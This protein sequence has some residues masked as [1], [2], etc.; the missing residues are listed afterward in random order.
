[1]TPEGVGASSVGEVAVP[2]PARGV[3]GRLWLAD[4]TAFDG[5]LA[6]ALPSGGAVTGEVVFNTVMSGY[7]EVLTDPSYAGQM[8]AFTYPHIG[9]YGV[10][11][12]DAEGSRVHA[13]AAV[14]RELTARPA[15]W[16]AERSLE[17][18]LCAEG[19][20]VLT[21]VDTRR[22]VRHIREAGAMTAAIGP[23]EGPGALGDGELLEVARRAPGTEG[24]D[25][26]SGVT[27]TAPYAVGDG[28]LRVVVY[29]F[30][31]KRS[32]LTLLGEWARV[33]VVPASTPAGE[34]LARRPDGVLLSN[35]PGDPSALP[36]AATAVRELLGEVPLFGICLGHQLLALAIGAE[37]YKLTFGHH[38][39]NHP[40]RRVRTGQVEITSQN[41]S[42]AVAA[43]TVAPEAVSHVNLNDGVVEGLELPEARAASVQ[44]H[45][46]AG[47]GPHDARYLLGEFCRRI[48]EGV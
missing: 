25:L 39:G 27:T 1:M 21:G 5:V 22:L 18:A 8:V 17:A 42:Y 3:R 43:E 14:V 30:G 20:T 2:A 46:E 35:G 16:R 24:R 11:E 40:V 10:A 29:D 37:T 6:G 28:R 45:P 36:G 33:E 47:P 7:W 26:V 15:S 34:V 12:A 41:H 44:Y 13:V 9:N 19:V 32:M 48:E 23:L 38:G 4:G 31:V